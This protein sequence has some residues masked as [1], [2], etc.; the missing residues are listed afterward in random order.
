MSNIVV[1]TSAMS[2]VGTT[3]FANYLAMRSKH[4]TLLLEFGGLSYSPIIHSDVNPNEVR[5]ILKVIPQPVT[6]R[7]NLFHTSNKLVRYC[8]K[9]FKEDASQQLPSINMDEILLEASKAFKEV[10]LDIP[11]DVQKPEHKAVFNETFREKYDVFDVILLDENILSFKAL[12]DLNEVLSHRKV[13]IRP[14]IVLS[15]SIR[16]YD[17]L[18][19]LAKEFSNIKPREIVKTPLIPKLPYYLNEGELFPKDEKL[20]AYLKVIEVLRKQVGL[21]ETSATLNE[22]IKGRR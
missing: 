6:L 11:S 4:S 19:D 5:S 15:K 22:L 18:K 12:A 8:S 13:T 20:E 10:I 9:N 1:V 14:V 17:H 2:Q 21:S 7:D 3:T 16:Y